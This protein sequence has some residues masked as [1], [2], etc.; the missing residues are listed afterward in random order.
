MYITPVK[1]L[2]KDIQTLAPMAPRASHDVTYLQRAA[3][4]R[5]MCGG[6]HLCAIA[7][8]LFLVLSKGLSIWRIF[9]SCSA[10]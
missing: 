10:F 7:F 4:K 2:I 3:E 1:Y 5:Y 8:C 9:N 6:E